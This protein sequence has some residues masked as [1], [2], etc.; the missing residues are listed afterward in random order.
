M[1]DINLVY[2]FDIFKRRRLTIAFC[3]AAVL[4][5]TAIAL[6]F[7]PKTYQ[8]DTTLLFPSQSD[9]NIGAQFSQLAGISISGMGFPGFSGREIYGT[10]LQS[11]ALS[12]S[13]CRSLRLDR[14]KLGYK[15]LQKHLAVEMPKE[16]HLIFRFEVPT[17]WLKGRVPD[18]EL[19]LR[20]AELSA[21]ITDAYIRE[22]TLYDRS[23]SLFLSKKSRLYVESQLAR[24]KSDLTRAEDRLSE[25]Q[26]KHPTLVPP[27]KSSAYAE[28]MLELT[29]KETETGVSLHE[30]E[31]QIAR[32]R[33]IWKAGAPEGVSP[34]AVIGSPII[35]ELQTELAKL[36]IKRATLMED[37]TSSH[38]DVVSLTQ[39]IEETQK[40]MGSEI[41][42]VVGGT[43]ESS[44]AAHQELLKQLVVLETSRDGLESRKSAL[45]ASFSR[46][47]ER[48]SGLPDQELEYARLMRD[49]KTSDV[50]YT[51]L[52]AEQAKARV[53]EGRDSDNFIV[54]DKAV[55]PEKPVK[56]RLRLVLAAALLVGLTLGA[57]VA[58]VQ[59]RPAGK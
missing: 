31:G 29:A 41:D 57:L 37:F 40:K 46:M 12:E 53:T 4:V 38:P 47:E 21:R 43:S 1:D 32:A 49:V 17:S 19:G 34:E 5:V 27:D 11:R 30:I 2:I 35:S 24:A 23:N 48:L 39:E 8:G 20:T 16:G 3:V 22:L 59:Y 44:S 51:T 14:Y 33:S 58:G 45:S 52:L 54:L 50:V 9:N 42:R 56:P 10:V 36:E 18:D 55:V 6:V 25:F 15:D 7:V 28:Q 13:V 26:R